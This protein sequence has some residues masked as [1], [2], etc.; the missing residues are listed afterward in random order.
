[1]CVLCREFVSQ[2][3]WTERHIE[4]RARASEPT[5]EHGEYHRFRRRDRSHRAKVINEVLGHYGLRVSDWAGSKY[6]LRNKKGRSVLVQD[7]G[8]LWPAAQR[9]PGPPLD[10]LDP[11]L[12]AG[13]HEA[14]RDEA[15]VNGGQSG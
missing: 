7:L 9:L 12:Q 1:M 13:L 2:L 11:A 5:G 15:P 14:S 10:P 8:S 4:D 3:H 6:L